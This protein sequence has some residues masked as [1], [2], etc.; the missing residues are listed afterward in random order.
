MSE[1]LSAPQPEVAPVNASSVPSEASKQYSEEFV[2]KI[3]NEK[4]N[5]T[6]RLKQLEDEKKQIEEQRLLE[7]NKWKE[8]AEMRESDLK[9]TQQKFQ[10][11]QTK[12]VQ[13]KKE[14]ALKSELRKRGCLDKYIDKTLGFAKMDAIK[15]DDE[16]GVVYGAETVAEQIQTEYDVFF[17]TSGPR[18]THAA[19]SMT[20][21][22]MDINSFRALPL[23]EQKKNMRKFYEA[24]GITLRD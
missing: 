8:I 12:I 21:Q 16:T 18:P 17:Q 14:S 3:L 2:N 13:A 6:L 4:K 15:I 9:V 23:D 20:P 5:T 7:Q 11:L 1:N 22:K 19:P 24:A 10:E